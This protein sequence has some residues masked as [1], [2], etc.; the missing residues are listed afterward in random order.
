MKRK[1]FHSNKN[2]LKYYFKIEGK[3]HDFNREVYNEY[4][5]YNNFAMYED[6]DKGFDKPRRM[7]IVLSIEDEIFFDEEIEDID[8]EIY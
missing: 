8:E 6:I 2:K 4:D 5:I 7:S 3:L 1:L